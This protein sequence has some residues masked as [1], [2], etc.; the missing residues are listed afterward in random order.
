MYITV[1]IKLTTAGLDVGPFNLYSDE[2]V[3]A[4]AFDINIP[5][6]TL[7]DGY[8]CSVVPENTTRIKIQSTGVIPPNYCDNYIIIDIIMTGDSTTSTTSTGT[9]CPPC[10]TTSTSTT[11]GNE[12]EL[13]YLIT[14]E[15]CGENC[16]K[17]MVL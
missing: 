14:K 4:G 17:Q 7:L 12:P 10:P 2:D 3:F 13:T 9:T 16:L 6:Q 8:L 11:T 1:F 5:R 15:T